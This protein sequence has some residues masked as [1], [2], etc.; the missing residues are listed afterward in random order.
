MA[1]KFRP[2]ELKAFLKSWHFSKAHSRILLSWSACHAKRLQQTRH[3]LSGCRTCMRAN[4]RKSDAESC[5]PT[6]SSIPRLVG[7]QLKP[8][9]DAMMDCV[10]F[11]GLVHLLSPKCASKG[12]LVFHV[13]AEKNKRTKQTLLVSSCYIIFPR[14]FRLTQCLTCLPSIKARKKDGSA[15]SWQSEGVHLKT[16]I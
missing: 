7:I 2:P 5:A 1:Q 12:K 11:T 9:N 10:L 16:S 14:G 8:N 15:N 3:V 6:P 4:L 13:P